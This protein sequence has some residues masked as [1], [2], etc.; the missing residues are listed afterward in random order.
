LSSSK[1]QRQKSRTG[2]ARCAKYVEIPGASRVGAETCATCHTDQVKDFQH[3][4]HAQQGVECEDCHGNGSLHVQG[5]GDVT[6][7][8]AFSKLPASAANGVCL[9]CHARSAKI[10]YWTAGS[11]AANHVRCVDCHQIHQ[12][13]LRTATQGQ[14]NFETATRGALAA[15]S[16]DKKPPRRNDAVT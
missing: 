11:H 16:M 10:R 5:G 15:E 9:S 3:A 7:I 4:Y 1:L 2:S 13:A 12:S 8:I 14:L 6:K